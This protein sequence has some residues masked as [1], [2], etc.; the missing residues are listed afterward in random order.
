MTEK[1]LEEELQEL[2]TRFVSTLGKL[3]EIIF[4]L[5]VL[6]PRSPTL[7]VPEL[8][9]QNFSESPTCPYCGRTFHALMKKIDCKCGASGKRGEWHYIYFGW[10]W[11]E[12]NTK[13]SNR[14]GVR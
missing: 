9:E 2:E 5:E 11:T 10:K 4:R 13:S 12:A 7:R 3:R 14:S 1:N 6:S 8:S